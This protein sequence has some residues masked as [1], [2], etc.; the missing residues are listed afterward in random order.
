MSESD[1]SGWRAAVAD[2]TRP[3]ARPAGATK[4]MG[5]QFELRERTRAST[6][7]WDAPKSRTAT[8]E[9]AR[10]PDSGLLRLG[11]R[12]VVAGATGNWVR[13]S[14][15]WT[16]LPHLLNRLS[17][18]PAQ[19]SWF[20]QF[21]ALHR[22]G[23]DVYVPGE[24]DWLFLDE[25]A[26]PLLWPLLAEAESLGIALVAGKRETDVVITDGAHLAVDVTGEPAG[27]L[28]LRTTVVIGDDAHPGAVAGA[29]G[30]HGV[31]VWELSPAPRF[32]LARTIEPLTAEHRR[33]LTDRDTITVPATEAQEFLAQYYPRL[34]TVVEVVS[35]DES[36]TF[37]TISPPVLVLTATFSS[38][39]RLDLS[40]GWLSPAGSEALSAHP[41]P[42]GVTELLGRAPHDA[43]LS[44][45]DAAE[46]ASTMLPALERHDEVRVD[47]VGERPGYRELTET[48]QL[49]VTTVETDKR[50]WFDLGVMVTV[51][52]RTI[53]FTPLFKALSRGRPKLLLVDK[54]Y[55]SLKQPVFDKLRELIE[56]AQSLDEW[57]PGGLRI[58]RYQASLWSEFVEL[59]DEAHQAESWSRTVDGLRAIREGDS[60]DNV[61]VPETVTA[62]LRPYQVQGFRW[63][64]FLWRHGLGGVLAD[65]MGLGKTLQTLALIAHA[66]D[67]ASDPHPFL[68]VAPT[69]VVSNWV[70]EAARFTPGLT[71]R[72]V[73]STQAASRQTLAAI[74]EGT[75]VVVTSYAL[76]RLDE[77]RY[78]AQKWAGLILDEAQ[79]IK[80]RSSKAHEAA[81]DL[82][83]PFKLAI[84]GTP[85]EN[86]LLDI[87]SL[88][89]VVSP[90]LLP[91]RLAFT[92]RYLKPMAAAER[93]DLLTRLRQR[94]RPLLLRRTKESVAA[95][96]P[97]K[98]EQ[99][100]RVELAPRHRKLYDLFLQRERQK[101]LGLVD[102]LDRNRF[103]VFR[104]LTLLRMMALDA[105]LVDEQYADV[106]SAKIEVLLDE[107]ADVM[108]GG[109]RA[110]VFSQFTSLLR[111]V[112]ERLDERAIE[113]DYLDGST[114]RR[115]EVIDHFRQGDAPVFLISLKAGGFGLNL[116][117]ADYVFLLDPWWNP[118]AEAQAVDRTH[119]IGQDSTVMVYR[120]IADDTVEDKVMALKD[121]KA[122][123]FDALMD[124]S[125]GAFDASLSADDIRGLLDS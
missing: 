103:I 78:R 88:F 116:T 58:S 91:P 50:D 124:D 13:G 98:Q 106:P 108:A 73:T 80:N 94:V 122:Q 111:R 118:A 51:E 8:P 63:L 67:H 2:L 70:S 110:L 101:L 125:G 4:A 97:A 36:V 30:D 56:E 112:A 72:A 29:I 90:G 41:V 5:L 61:P 33:L 55:L 39:D 9:I 85:M 1:A 32:T 23:R 10:S 113:Y 47:I 107:L 81:V 22:S 49:V 89:R 117:E 115:A 75:D 77:A 46:F 27:G 43:E 42:T 15:T 12:P 104:S 99:T 19:H 119:R 109:H 62:E 25:F 66:R 31:S 102:D 28:Q 59:A 3:A 34:Q 79:L 17:L 84:T 86:S 64:V 65:D 38:D 114:R 16:T 24:A 21:A 93:P 18:I 105:S 6:S 11:V 71:V 68:V 20:G 45:L 60:L 37:P 53:P 40:W 95:E 57:E 69:S 76:F 44:G 87:W 96:L 123:L 14:L 26:S 92:E 82:D 52:G 120:M 121:K 7:R 48:P 83:V 54:T 74:A 35:S 100:L